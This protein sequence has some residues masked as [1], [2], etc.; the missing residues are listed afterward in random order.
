METYTKRDTSNKVK[1]VSINSSERIDTEFV[2]LAIGHSARDTFEMLYQKGIHME[3]KDF[4]VGFR[5]EHPQGLIN[6]EM[7]GEEMADKMPSAP[8]KVTAKR[9]REEAHILFVCVP[10]DMW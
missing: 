9:L 7:Y 8:Y 1:S 3:A 6:F 4:A 2:V 5:V 10:E